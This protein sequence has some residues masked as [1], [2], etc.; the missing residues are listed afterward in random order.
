MANED[1]SWIMD[2]FTGRESSDTE[3]DPKMT[4]RERVD[5][6]MGA[7]YELDRAEI[8]LGQGSD[9]IEMGST[10]NDIGDVI[11]VLKNSADFHA[12]QV[13]RA[14]LKDAVENGLVNE[15]EAL[16]LAEYTQARDSASDASL[17]S[18]PSANEFSG[19]PDENSQSNA[20]EKDD[21]W[22]R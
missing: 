6:F 21:G 22:E 9:T 8:A 12:A 16:A 18:P 20:P 15:A 14:E 13:D 1:Q 2:R 4:V 11:E 17:G 7:Q 19:W 10:Y 3:P 5:R